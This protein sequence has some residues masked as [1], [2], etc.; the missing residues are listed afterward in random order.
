M[1]LEIK[2]RKIVIYTAIFGNKDNL[3][4]PLVVPQNCDFI[5]FTDNN[6]LSSN[7]WKI[8]KVER[9]FKDPVREARRY[10][11]LVHKFLNEYEYSVWIDGNLLLRRDPQILI[12]KY[13]QNCN[14][15]VFNHN[16]HK[17]KFKKLFWVKDKDDC[18]NCIYQ[19]AEALLK[20]AQNG[21]YKDDPILIK[22]Q[23]KKY[24]K[25]NY[26]VSEG[27]AV[28]MVL[29]R[30]HNALDVVKVMEE[31]WQEVMNY[32]RRDQLSFNYV[33]W[34]NNFKFNY[35]KGD[36]RRN[37]YFFY[38]RHKIKESFKT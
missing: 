5:C 12:N 9:L 7:V 2:N 28:T 13:L 33:A 16:A 20:M 31:W 24:K 10:K 36:S 14:L 38:K 32:S 34:K 18:R 30:K 35:I 27:L 1:P 21:K 8:K 17:K 23:I 22:N 4:D 19:E 37:K 25:E 15:A 6:S 26:P 11:I 3:I 29:L